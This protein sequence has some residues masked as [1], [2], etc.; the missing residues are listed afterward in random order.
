MCIFNWWY[1]KENF[2]QIVEIHDAEPRAFRGL[3]RFL[4]SGQPPEN[5]NDVAL[6]LLTL[7]DKYGN[8]R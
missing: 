5:F 6:E 7:A 3:L 4:Y 1:M 8:T 2:T